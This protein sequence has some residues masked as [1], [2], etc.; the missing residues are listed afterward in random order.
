MQ[1]NRKGALLKNEWREVAKSSFLLHSCKALKTTR[2]AYIENSV[3]PV[4]RGGLFLFLLLFFVFLYAGL[5]TGQASKVDGQP[6]TPILHTAHQVQ[7]QPCHCCQQMAEEQQCLVQSCS[8]VCILIHG[9]S[10]FIQIEWVTSSTFFP[11]LLLRLT[12]STFLFLPSPEQEPFLRPP[13]YYPNP[14]LE[15]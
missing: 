10:S 8:V 6:E 2:L 4:L 11:T 13:R 9:F 5:L 1:I 3:S 12:V 15:S 14:P 7:D